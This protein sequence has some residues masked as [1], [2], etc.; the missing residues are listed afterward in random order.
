[1]VRTQI[2]L[3]EM[4][5][6]TVK[7]VALEE[8]I[9]IAEVIRQAVEK[10]GETRSKLGSQEKAHRAIDIAGKYRSGKKDVSRKHDEYLVEGYEK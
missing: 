9:S 7:R 2:Q 4:Q 3:T 10:I 1:M 6:K 8:G 5:A